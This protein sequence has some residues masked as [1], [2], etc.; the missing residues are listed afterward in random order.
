VSEREKGGGRGEG[1]STGVETTGGQGAGQRGEGMPAC[2]PGMAGRARGREKQ[3]MG[4]REER[5]VKQ[6]EK[7]GEAYR[8][9]RRRWR[10]PTG[11]GSSAWGREV[12][13]GVGQQGREREERV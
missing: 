6:K 2:R 13:E 4:E 11:G 12:G 9:E 5:E 10:S 7:R 1:G 8:R 3:R